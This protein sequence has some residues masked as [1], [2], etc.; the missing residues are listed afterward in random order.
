MYSQGKYIVGEIKS[1]YGSIMT[2]LCFNET[3]SHDTFHSLFN[4]IRSAGFFWVNED[5]QIV[6]TGKSVSLG[7]DSREEDI[8]QIARALGM[9]ETF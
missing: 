3:V 2:A 7:V 9:G 6:V 1:N 8:L 4:E 5:G